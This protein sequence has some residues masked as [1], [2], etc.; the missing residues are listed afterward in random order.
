MYHVDHVGP[1]Y[2]MGIITEEVGCA[3]TPGISEI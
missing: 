2:Q 1:Y 3:Y